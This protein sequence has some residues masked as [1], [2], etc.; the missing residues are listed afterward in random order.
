[1]GAERTRLLRNSLLT[2]YASFVGFVAP[3]PAD[4]SSG[5]G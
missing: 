5:K 3:L 2:R 1:M 4:T